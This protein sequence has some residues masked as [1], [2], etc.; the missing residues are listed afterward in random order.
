MS[1]LGPGVWGEVVVVV[2]AFLQGPAET[3]FCD[4]E[5]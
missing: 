4:V 2:S 3:T 5:P 1:V